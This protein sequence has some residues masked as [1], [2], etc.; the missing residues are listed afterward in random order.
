MTTVRYRWLRA[1]ATTLIV[2]Y[3]GSKLVDRLSSAADVEQLISGVM[4]MLEAK[5]HPAEEPAVVDRDGPA[6]VLRRRNESYGNCGETGVR[7]LAQQRS[8]ELT[9]AVPTTRG[10]D[11]EVQGRKNS[12]EV[13]RRPHLDP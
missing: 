9:S 7:P 10:C 1:P 4:V 3:L 13:C 12:A 8:R 5:L 6:P 2:R 11:D